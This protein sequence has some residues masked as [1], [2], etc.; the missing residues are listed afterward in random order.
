MRRLVIALQALFSRKRLVGRRVFLRP[1]KRRDAKKWQSIRRKSSDFLIPW[2][3]SWDKSAC[4]RRT[5][6][7]QLRNSANQANLDKA[8]S[9][10]I[11]N[12]QNNAMLGGINVGNVRRG[13]SQSA[14][15]GY[16]IGQ[17]FSNQGYMHEALVVLIPSLFIDLRLNRLEAATLPENIPSRKLLE[18]IGFKEEGLMRNYLK[19]NGKWRDHIIYGL[20]SSDFVN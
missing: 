14:A 11:F 20:L 5:F 10:Y 1:P 8:Y 7:R 3:P 16:W 17:P 9:F 6:M 18:K 2:E 12:S 13:A 15:L 4:S 19:I